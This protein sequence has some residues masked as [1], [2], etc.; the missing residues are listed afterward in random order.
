MNETINCEIT[1][2]MIETQ[3][4]IIQYIYIYLFS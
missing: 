4:I 2:E 1:E 3:L